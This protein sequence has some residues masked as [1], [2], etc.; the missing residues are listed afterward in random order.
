MKTPRFSVLIPTYNRRQLLA[1]AIDSVLA[2]TFPDYEIIVI[3]DGSIDGT[4]TMLQSYGSHIR[5]LSQENRGG[6]VARSQGA[7]IAAGDYLVL[8][9]DDDVLYPDALAI[10][11]RIIR[12]EEAPPLIVGAMS[13]FRDGETPT[14]NP[15]GDEGIMFL[16][17]RDYLSKDVGF[18]KSNSRIVVKRS[19][20]E[21]TGALRAVP[22][23]FPCDDIN[24]LLLMG[25]KGPFVFIQRPYTVAYREH[26]SNTLK[27]VD[28][29]VEGCLKL[30]RFER[31]GKYP[32]GRSRRFNRYACI[33]G[34]CSVFTYRALKQGR[35]QLASKLLLR[36]A[37]M[38]AAA[39]INK[40]GRY[41]R[42]PTPLNRLP[43]QLAILNG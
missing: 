25:T 12:A 31:H 15:A 24:L 28:Y 32:G 30:A 16:R 7:A 1:Q 10:Y 40:L 38:I 39:V 37:P 5:V 34:G 4:V 21:A 14:A 22:P 20:A 8:L 43:A 3:D 11:D 27:R 9:D 41:F 26:D 33:G 18:G 13:Y 35:L 36:T 19:M 17:F 29:I 2:Q 6:Q 42:K 23:P